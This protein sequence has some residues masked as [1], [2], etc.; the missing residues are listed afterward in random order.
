MTVVTGQQPREQGHSHFWNSR[1]TPCSSTESLSVYTKNKGDEKLDSLE[2]VPN[3]I[4][5]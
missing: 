2:A 4:F 3:L 1:H 5:Q